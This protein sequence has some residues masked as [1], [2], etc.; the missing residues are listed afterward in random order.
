[1]ATES[2][3]LRHQCAMRSTPH[4]LRDEGGAWGS[5]RCS[6]TPVLSTPVPSSLRGK[7]PETKRWWLRWCKYWSPQLHLAAG[8]ETAG[9]CRT[10]TSHFR[11]RL[12]RS[13]LLPKHYARNST[14]Y[15]RHVV[16][17]CSEPRTNGRLR[18]KARVGKGSEV[19]WLSEKA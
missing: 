14:A 11:C 9:T 13:A 2:R 4:I 8:R 6:A 1:M 3:S 19:V 10:C 7:A 16:W 12:V 5:K 15:A 18:E 17:T